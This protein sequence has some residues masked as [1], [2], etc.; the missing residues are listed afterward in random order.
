[1]LS[2]TASE[3]FAI[4]RALFLLLLLSLILFFR[5]CRSLIISTR[6][7]ISQHTHTVVSFTIM[8]IFKFA[9]ANVCV[10][11]LIQNSHFPFRSFVS[12]SSHEQ[13]ELLSYWNFIRYSYYML[14]LLQPDSCSKSFFFSLLALC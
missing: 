11:F 9:D 2:H 8:F 1:M 14:L 6:F 10:F 12:S 7:F 3:A 5:R 4:P 13:F